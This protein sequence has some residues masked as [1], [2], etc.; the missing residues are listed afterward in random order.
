MLAAGSRI[1]IADADSAFA[2]NLARH[3][4]DLGHVVAGHAAHLEQCLAMVQELRPDLLLL[5]AD[6]EGAA[7]AALAIREQS[8]TAVILLT[9][10]SATVPVQ[11]GAEQQR[12]L[13]RMNRATVPFALDAALNR[14]GRA[15]CRERVCLAV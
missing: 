8:G 12:P 9:S 1:L 2:A 6:A 13:I 14:S 11:T 15:S 10:A 4:R 5:D 3:L 7:A